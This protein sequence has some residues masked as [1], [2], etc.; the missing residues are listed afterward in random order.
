MWLF[1]KKAPLPE[2]ERP[3]ENVFASAFSTP[4]VDTEEEDWVAEAL[5]GSGNANGLAAPQRAWTDRAVG[6]TG[7]SRAVVKPIGASVE[8]E[9]RV[10]RSIVQPI[11]TLDSIERNERIPVTSSPP[12][13]ESRDHPPPPPADF[14]L[15]PPTARHSRKTR[16]EVTHW[17]VS[18]TPDLKS[19]P[20]PAPGAS[21]PSVGDVVLT[22]PGMKTAAELAGLDGPNSSAEPVFSPSSTTQ[23]DAPE[24]QFELFGSSSSTPK[25][26][27][28]IRPPGLEALLTALEDHDWGMDSN[29]GKRVQTKSEV[30]KGLQDAL[31]AEDQVGTN[32][33]PELVPDAPCAFRARFYNSSGAVYNTLR[34]R[35]AMN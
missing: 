17:A 33:P 29:T 3:P 9:P 11:G 18:G 31:E 30:L 34:V 23:P 26:K 35:D 5:H 21:A 16:L 24:P 4:L 15:P 6:Q 2:K 13:S 32:E 1:R 22:A 7:Q 25:K 19:I 10:E 12:D 14:P 27:V 28:E 8:R 20:E